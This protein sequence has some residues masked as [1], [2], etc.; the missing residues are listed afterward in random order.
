MLDAT[1]PIRMQRSRGV[2]TVR[3]GPRGLVDMAQSGAAK[4]MLPRIAQGRPE[5]VFLNTSG[6][7]ASGDRLDY[8]IG[9][10]AGT[11][12]LATTQTA[13]R[14]YRAD[15]TPAEVSLC[16]QVGP[17]SWLD[18][19]PQETILYDGARLKRQTVVDLG[20]GAGC[21]LLEAIV[22]GRIAMGEVIRN[23]R[24]TDRR[25]IRRN[26]RMIHHDALALDDAALSR[27]QGPAMLGDARAMAALTMIAPH[28]PD[29]L[30]PARAALTEPGVTGAASAAPGR[31]ILRLL[32]RDNWPLRQQIHRLLRVLRPEP[33]PRIW[34]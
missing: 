23:L 26:G 15:D 18:W 20:S 17:G 29:L 21:L 16:L 27:L 2:A 31:L 5:I 7:L 9:L 22:L 4:V 8:R 28:A 24:L 11:N 6:G 32:S 33:L 10:A 34:V 3:L 25:I 19:L 13:E 30:A 14:A 12:A 1:A